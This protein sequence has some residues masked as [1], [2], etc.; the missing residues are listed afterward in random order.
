M[1]AFGLIG[2]A[3]VEAASRH[4]HKIISVDIGSPEVAEPW[5][6]R[7]TTIRTEMVKKFSLSTFVFDP[8]QDPLR[9]A[10]IVESFSPSAIVNC[11][12]NSLASEFSTPKSI[13]EE[14]M[15]N[16][17]QVLI[18][19]CLSAQARY[20][21]VSSSMV[22]GNFEEVPVRESSSKNP[23]DPYGA[24]KLGCEH[25]IR[26]FGHQHE[27]FDFAILRPSAVYGALDSNSRALV[28]M[29]H[30]IDDQGALFVRN[31]TEE[32]DFTPV[33]SLAEMIVRVLEHTG[34]IRA[35]YNASNG[36]AASMAEVVNAF[37]QLLSDIEFSVHAGQET[38]KD[39]V[40]PTRGTLS[41]EL[42]SADFGEIKREEILEG[43]RG[44]IDDSRRF[45]LLCGRLR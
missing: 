31:P 3:V 18:E 17:N 35:T 27:F 21:Y 38:E 33:A 23:I 28:K 32:L 24:L 45:K 26:A 43:L 9:F 20:I 34:R 8:G 7:A 5:K 6:A 11:G 15:T 4:G 12:G 39:I 19:R 40:R 36:Q 1:G 16:L 42:F 14:T 13:L 10:E 44:L 22:Y 2:S 41:M 25:L 30:S 37:R 29:L